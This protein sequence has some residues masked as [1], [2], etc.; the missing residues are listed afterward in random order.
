MVSEIFLAALNGTA[1]AFHQCVLS[2]FTF[3]KGK[4]TW[5]KKMELEVMLFGHSQQ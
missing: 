5:R 3:E 4:E 1:F 2:I